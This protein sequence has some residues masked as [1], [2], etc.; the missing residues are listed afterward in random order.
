MKNTLLLMVLIFTGLLGCNQKNSKKESNC[1]K[2]AVLGVN[3]EDFNRVI[4]GKP[5]KLYTIENKNGMKVQITNFGGRIVS[6]IVPDKEG[7]FGDVSLG[8]STLDEYLDDGMYQSGI[9]GRFGNRIKEG[10]FSLNGRNYQLAV[11]DGPNALH[12]GTKGYNKVVWDA[13]QKENTLALSYVSADME[14][15]YP[16][17]LTITVTYSL[18]ESN[19][20]TMVY[21]ATTT[22]STVVNLTNH[23]YYNLKGDG[24]S[25]ILDHHLKMYASALTPVDATLIPTGEISDVSGTP[26]D[27]RNGKLIGKDIKQDDQQLEFG[28]GYDHNWVLDKKGNELELALELS[29]PT[30]GRVMKMYTTEPGMQFYSGNFM[31]GTVEGKSGE[32]YQYRCALALEPQHF[33]DSP[34][35]SGFPSTVLNPGEMYYHKST[36]AFSVME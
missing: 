11:N 16:G 21:E 33:P 35:Q 36:L 34:N 14:E 22:Q 28:F 26:F 17:E 12:G 24:D 23:T 20:L 8:Y 27:F 25:S 18:S 3:A 13:Q 32:K 4:D 6:I 19:E 5:V 1:C 7:V 15:G 9:I 30:S 2:N 31:N 10:K 29:E